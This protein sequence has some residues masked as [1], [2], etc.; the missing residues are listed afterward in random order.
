MANTV[1]TRHKI[2]FIWLLCLLLRFASSAKCINR[3]PSEEKK[4]LS[5]S[6]KSCQNKYSFHLVSQIPHFLWSL[7][8]VF[9]VSCVCAHGIR[10][11]FRTKFIHWMWKLMLMQQQTP[12]KCSIL[13][14]NHSKHIAQ[15]IS[16]ATHIFCTSW[17][18]HKLMWNFLV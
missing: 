7:S 5:F 3:K 17:H 12:L 14:E 16:Q 18:S 8:K 10:M 11:S 15:R 1:G 4:S 6:L 2:A 9:S 13:D